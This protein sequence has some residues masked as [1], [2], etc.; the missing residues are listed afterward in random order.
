MKAQKNGG[1]FLSRVKN[2]GNNENSKQFIQSHVK[3]ERRR[4]YD[5]DGVGEDGGVDE[6]FWDEEDGIRRVC[7]VKEFKS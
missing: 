5:A 3:K 4:R 1:E 7:G 2:G 6:A